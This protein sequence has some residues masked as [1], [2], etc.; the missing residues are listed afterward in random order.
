MPRNYAYAYVLF[1][2]LWEFPRISSLNKHRPQRVKDTHKKD[3]KKET[4]RF[5]DGDARLGVT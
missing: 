2:G 4:A 5:V 3:L 1:L